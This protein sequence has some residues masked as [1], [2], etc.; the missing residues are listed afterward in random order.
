MLLYSD[1]TLFLGE[2]QIKKNQEETKDEK[3]ASL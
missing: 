1:L 2:I 3:T